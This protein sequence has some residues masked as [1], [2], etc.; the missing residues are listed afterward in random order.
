MSVESISARISTTAE[1]AGAAIPAKAATPKEDFLKLLVAQLQH[2]DPMQPQ[3][4]SQFVA[5]LATFASLEQATQTNSMLK[6]L[7]EGQSSSSNASF[8]ALVGKNVTARTD[9]VELEPSG[10]LPAVMAHLD[11]AAKKVE[12]VI[13]DSSGRKV[14]T[15]DLGARAPGDIDVAWDGKAEKGIALPP[16]TYKVMVKAVANDGSEVG[17]FAEVR[18]LIRSLEFAGGSPRF[19]VGSSTVA[20]ADIV[21]ILG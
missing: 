7:V 6:Q 8:A 12:V 20:P 5:Q 18:G 14:R 15:I 10:A 9:T 1:G 17:G 3:D 11:S 21:S 2:Q 13:T 16:G 4:G 19:R